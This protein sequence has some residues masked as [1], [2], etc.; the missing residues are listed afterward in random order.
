MLAAKFFD[1]LF[2]NNAFYAKLG[3]VNPAEMNTLEVE[4]L[5]LLNFSLMVR[6]DVFAKYQAELRNFNQVLLTPPLIFTMAP[7]VDVCDI[8]PRQNYRQNYATLT[9]YDDHP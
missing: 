1:D 5:H 6:P 9:R 8:Y 7:L 2:Y 4:L 3:G